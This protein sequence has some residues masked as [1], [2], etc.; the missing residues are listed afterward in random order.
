MWVCSATALVALNAF[1]TLGGD[2]NNGAILTFTLPLGKRSN[3]SV[4]VQRQNNVDHAFAQVQENLPAGTGSGY[5]VSAEV[6]P[7][8]VNRRN[9]IIKAMLAPIGWAQ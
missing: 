5:R 2:G 7:E 8:A 3:V 9:M 1:H 4:G 6:G